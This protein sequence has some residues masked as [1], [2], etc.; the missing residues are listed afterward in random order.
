MPAGG[1]VE[2]LRAVKDA[3]E[4]EAIRA[5]ARLAD[6]GADRGPRARARGPH[7]ARGRARPRVHDAPPG[8]HRPRRSRR[9]SP[10]AS[11]ARCRTPT[12]RDVADPRRHAVR[13]STG[14]RSSTATRRTARAPTPPAR[15]TARD[16]QVYALV[17]HAQEAALEAVRPGPTGREVDA[18]ARAIID[19]AGHA[20]HFGHG[21]GHG[22]GLD[23]HEGPRLSK[24]GETALAAGHGRHGRAGRL[25]AGRRRRAHRG[26][27]RSSPTTA[28]R[29]SPRC[30]RSSRSSPRSARAA[31]R[32]SDQPEPADQRHA[33][34]QVEGGLQSGPTASGS[35]S[36]DTQLS[37]VAAS[38]TIGGRRA[39]TSQATSA[40]Q[41][42]SA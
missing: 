35:S 21:L 42:G 1:A 41:A 16:G 39:W 6:D 22:V 11:T 30:P 36:K 29:S 26:P 2:A 3:D 12:P 37:A 8:A 4:L 20:E 13:R 32:R 24:Q 27:R 25:R 38:A 28:P 7:R 10:P 15:S 19:A 40:R 33:P 17:L 14:A 5:A 31:G 18:V 34:R 23:V 9:S